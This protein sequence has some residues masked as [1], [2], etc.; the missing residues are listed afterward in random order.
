MIIS[1]VFEVIFDGLNSISNIECLK[2]GGAFYVFANIKK[3][4]K[5]SEEIAR[6]LLKDANIAVLPGTNFGKYGEG[7]IR[8]CYATSL[9]NINLGIQRISKSMRKI[10]E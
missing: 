8:L 1:L 3:T 10:N 6:F 5:S 2:P 7:Y 4:G 9:K